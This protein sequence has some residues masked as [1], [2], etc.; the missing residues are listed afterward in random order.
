MIVDFERMIDIAKILQGIERER[1]EITGQ[2]TRVYGTDFTRP[3]VQG[4]VPSYRREELLDELKRIDERRKIYKTEQDIEINK[5]LAIANKVNRPLLTEMLLLKYE[6][7][8]NNK[9]IG[10]ILGYSESH[11]RYMLRLARRVIY[12]CARKLNHK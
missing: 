7:G 8:L 11:V 2:L 12:D 1:E 3:V 10:K 6:K 5:M 9:D 4:G